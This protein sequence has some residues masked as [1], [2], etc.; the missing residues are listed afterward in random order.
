[1]YQCFHRDVVREIDPESEPGSPR[2]LFKLRL[3]G[4]P[5]LQ[6]GLPN[7]SAKEDI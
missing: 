1:M 3:R 5:L 2:L 4:G 7:L 6:E